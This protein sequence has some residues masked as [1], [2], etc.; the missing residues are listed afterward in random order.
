VNTYQL[1]SEDVN[2]CATVYESDV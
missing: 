2:V 1:S